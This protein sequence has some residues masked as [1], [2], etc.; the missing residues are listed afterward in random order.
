MMASAPE[1]I[2]V[3]GI[4]PAARRDTLETLPQLSWPFVPSE[5][6]GGV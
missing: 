4:R 3:P 5:I 6:P 1:G 2:V